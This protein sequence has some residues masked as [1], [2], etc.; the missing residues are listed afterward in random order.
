MIAAIVEKFSFAIAMIALYVQSRIHP[1]DLT[2]AGADLFFG[3][4][5]AIAFVKTR[6]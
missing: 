6:A 3:L 4:L 5:F 2:F 1:S